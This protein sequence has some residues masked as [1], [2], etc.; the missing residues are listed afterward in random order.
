M[1]VF[2]SFCMSVFVSLYMCYTHLLLRRALPTAAAP[3]VVKQITALQVLHPQEE[4]VVRL[5][6]EGECSYERVCH[7]RHDLALPLG[8]VSGIRVHPLLVQDLHR[9]MSCM[10]HRQRVA[11][12]LDEH[13]RA[14]I[15]PT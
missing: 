5:E 4:L 15:P 7:T 3:E 1:S 13:H 12:Q 2:V 10:L 11:F 14:E 6:G 8:A 9:M